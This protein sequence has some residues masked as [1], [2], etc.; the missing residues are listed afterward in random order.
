ML[1]TDFSLLAAILANKAITPLTTLEGFMTDHSNVNASKPSEAVE[2]FFSYSHKDEELRDELANHLVMLKRQGIIS[3]WHD[4]EISAGTE[5]ANAID[6]NLDTADLILLLISANFLASDYCFDLELKR[7]MERHELQEA[8]VVPIILKSVDW[9]GAPF[10]KLQALPKNAKPVTTWQ[11]RDEAFLNVAQGIR[12]TVEEIAKS[13]AGG[14]LSLATPVDTSHNISTNTS[15]SVSSSSLSDRQRRRLE[16]ERD[17][18][19]QQY[20]LL[21]TK[22]D[23]LRQSY[24][25]E[26]DPAT[27]L[28]LEV[29]LQQAQTELNQ[30]DQ[31]IEQIE[32]QLK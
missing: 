14:S 19:Q 22:L 31:Q 11:N 13:K 7:A 1:L 12:R 26:V 24:S 28:K 6:E 5:W 8:R 25:I 21:G 20:D 29:Q 9:S 4:R 32:Q 23:R 27:K 30:V 3:A 2:V 16:Q 17:S 15:L 18:L 10:G